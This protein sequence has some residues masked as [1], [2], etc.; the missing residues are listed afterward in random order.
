M[1]TNHPDHGSRRCALDWPETS[2]SEYPLLPGFRL[3]FRNS[4]LRR[5]G[6]DSGRCLASGTATE[7]RLDR[8]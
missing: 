6:R 3:G 4:L 7:R 2:T 5:A 1:G 8:R